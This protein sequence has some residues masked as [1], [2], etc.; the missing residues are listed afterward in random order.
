MAV[1]EYIAKDASGANFS[2]T[3]KD[4][5]NTAELKDEL[6]KMGYT[7]VKAKKEG[8]ERSLKGKKITSGEIV[9]FAYEFSGMYNAGLSVVRCLE[10]LSEQ[11]ENPALKKIIIEVREKVESG[12]TL[13]EAFTPY[14]SVFSEI[15]LGMVEAG[16][17]GGELGK[18]LELAAKY[19]DKQEAIRKSVKSAFAYP[20][21]VGTMC[22]IITTALI[23]FV[24]PVFQKLYS[25]LNMKL[26]FMTQILIDISNIMRSW[27]YILIPALAGLFF[28]ITYALKNPKVKAR[29]DNYKLKMPIFGTL[30]RMVVVSRFVRTFSMTISA[31]VPLVEALNLAVDVT[32]N[33]EMKRVGKDVLQKVMTGSSLSGPMSEWPLFPPII[34]QLAAAGEEAGVLPE[35]LD[36]GI[37]F[38]DNH[39]ERAVKSLIVKIEPVMS[40]IM[41]TVVGGILLG[42]YLPMFDYMSQL[43]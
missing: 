13:R 21:V 27:W 39:I 16:E 36:K 10:T 33:N 37:E 5:R 42:V 24:I 12:E 35:M 30:N 28:A 1:F 25:N 22:L 23:I 17:A 41:G 11:A 31:G 43:K 29:I 26:P 19:L 8:T 9:N 2:G 40:L 32:N 38:L 14:Q 7:L 6:A 3:Y 4:I 18:T 34:V 20:I 15:F